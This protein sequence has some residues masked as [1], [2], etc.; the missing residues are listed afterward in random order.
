MAA[1]RKPV[2]VIREMIR[3]FLV[4][5]KRK[6]QNIPLVATIIAFA[7]YSFNL[8]VISFTTTRLQGNNMG[9][10]GFAIM[11]FST[12]A[13]VCCMNAFPYRKKVN[14]PMLV[15]LYVMLAIVLVCDNHYLSSVSSGLARDVNFDS[16]TVEKAQYAWQVMYA[17]SIMVMVCAALAA[18]LP[19]Y[20]KLIRKINTS[21]QVEE[22]A[23]ME[24]IDISGE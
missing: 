10:T 9:L 24:A 5:L 6:P 19:L 3:K 18:T 11:L 15:L 8:S 7:W 22:N 2:A 13:I 17:H 20:R 16:A 4:A 23:E 14:K 12:L 21:I 1:T